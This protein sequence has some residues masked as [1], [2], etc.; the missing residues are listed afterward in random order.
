MIDLAA[1]QT[2]LKAWVSAVLPN[3]PNDTTDT[4]R[5]FQIP[6]PYRIEIDEPS[7]I[8]RIGED[9]RTMADSVNGPVFT[10]HGNRE[11][12]VT[13]RA[14]GRTHTPNS[15]AQYAIEE[16]KTSLKKPSILTALQAAG[17]AVVR[18]G[19]TQNYN[20]P[21]DQREESIAAMVVTFGMAVASVDANTA[22]QIDSVGVSSAL[23]VS[24]NPADATSPP[25]VTDEILRPPP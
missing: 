23:A 17:I 8:R 2:A 19:N 25:N 24:G 10:V 16:L 3:V 21:R 7:S 9:W 11:L 20:A 5:V 6:A 1:F 14:R 15:S 13:I 22:G 12:D 4:K 18:T